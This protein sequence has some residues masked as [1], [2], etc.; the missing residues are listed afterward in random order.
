MP[1]LIAPLAL[2]YQHGPALRESRPP[3]ENGGKVVDEGN[4]IA[5]NGIRL[6]R[7]PE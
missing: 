3:K 6:E 1:Y 2:E 5:I 4:V 7:N